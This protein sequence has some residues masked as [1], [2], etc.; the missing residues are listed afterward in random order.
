[1]DLTKLQG[2]QNQLNCVVTRSPPLICSV[3]P[4]SSLHWLPL[5]YRIDFKICLLIYNP[6]KN[7]NKNKK[8]FYLQT[9][10]GTSLPSSSLRSYQGITLSS[11]DQDQCRHKGI[12]LLR[13]FPV[14]QRTAICSF[15]S[16][17]CNLPETSEDTSFDWPFLHKHHWPVDV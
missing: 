13:P 4:L 6:D 5:K 1:M 17:N 8:P 10:L 15:S 7:K 3:Q 16:L 11:L 12:S 9:M 14:E 2:I